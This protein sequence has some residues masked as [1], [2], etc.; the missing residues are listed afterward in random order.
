MQM[1]LKDAEKVFNKLQVEDVPCKH[2]RAGFLVVDGVRVL[3]VH[4]SFGVGN[5]SP[6]VAHLFRKSLKMS[7]EEFQRFI[8]CTMSREA[9]VQS[10]RDKGHLPNV[11]SR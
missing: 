4:H 3:K 7:M 10:L 9:Y 5:M 6:T 1:S 11:V 8:G 2:H